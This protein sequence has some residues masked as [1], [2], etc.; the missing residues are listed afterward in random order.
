LPVSCNNPGLRFSLSLSECVS[1]CVLVSVSTSLCLRFSP[2]LSCVSSLCLLVC[3]YLLFLSLSSPLCFSVCFS[4]VLMIVFVAAPM[5]HSNGTWFLVCSNGRMELYKSRGWPLSVSLSLSLCLYVSLPLFLSL[6]VCLSVCFST[7][8]LVCSNGRMELNKSRGRP[9]SPSLCLFLSLSLSLSVSVSLSLSLSL[10][11][12]LLVLNV[13]S[14]MRISIAAFLPA[15]CSSLSPSLS[16]SNVLSLTL[17]LPSFSQYFSVSVHLSRSSALC[18]NHHR[19][20][21]SCCVF[22]SLTF[23]LSSLSNV[24]CVFLYR[25]LHSL[26]CCALPALHVSL[27][28]ANARRSEH[29]ERV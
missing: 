2:S 8:F 17:S 15:E 16:I 29:P 5:Q 24:L 25:Y 1:I 13:R 12:F 3:L 6:S 19:R 21:P 26:C 7:R 27:N 22:S 4:K 28:F 11:L 9:L 10:S 20:I 18:V 14:F 23:S